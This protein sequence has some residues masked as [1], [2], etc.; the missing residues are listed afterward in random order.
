METPI[1]GLAINLL[2]PKA[3]TSFGRLQFQFAAPRDWNQLQQELK[4]IQSSQAL[5]DQ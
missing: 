3:C 2:I 1:Y 5:C 4:L